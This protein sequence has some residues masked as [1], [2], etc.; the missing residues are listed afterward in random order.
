MLSIDAAVRLLRTQ[1]QHAEL[2]RDAYLGPD[3]LESAR[4]FAVSSE[5]EE[6]K[7]LL[8]GRIQNGVIADLGSGT[9]IASWAFAQSGAKRIYA[10]EPDHSSEVGQGAISKLSVGSPI[11]ILAAAGEEIPLGDGTVDIVYIRQVLHH[12][13][14][15]PVMLRECVRILK[16]GGLFLACRE[17]VVDDESQKVEFLKNHPMHQLT[18]TEN[19]YPLEKYI[20]AINGADLSLLNI[21]GPWDSI[22]NAFPSVHSN[23]ELKDYARLTLQRHLGF[24][25]RLASFVPGVQALIW[26]R[27]RRPTPGRMFTFLA[28]KQVA[29]A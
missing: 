18:G 2:I 8:A 19:A 5:F 23:E 14:D 1:P 24:M 3:V 22:I 4:R 9:G 10:L 13:Q 16:E 29:K 25:G 20:E 28:K 11:E 15:L 12:I 27:L 26:R 17:H 7:R 6:V 21:F